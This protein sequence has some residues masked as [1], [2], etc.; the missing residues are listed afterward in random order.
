MVCHVRLAQLIA[1]RPELRARLEDA[2]SATGP[3]RSECEKEFTVRPCV[4]RDGGDALVCAK[5]LIEA[6]EVLR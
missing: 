4:V 3:A 5:T 6:T 1:L 2:D